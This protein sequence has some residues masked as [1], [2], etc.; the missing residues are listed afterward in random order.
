MTKK[1]YQMVETQEPM[2]DLESYLASGPELIRDED[3]ALYWRVNSGK[4]SRLAMMAR[5]YLAIPATSASSERSF[6]VGRHMLGLYRHSFRSETMEAC[7]CL[8]SG[9]RA[10][11]IAMDDVSLDD[12][13][14]VEAME[15]GEVLLD[16]NPEF[17]FDHLS[18]D[19]TATRAEA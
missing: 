5:D 19:D 14:A 11:L 4:W 6:S 2:D 13:A 12:I 16:Q 8:R 17:L 18:D 7:V 10:G 9:F 1:I 3:V 15:A